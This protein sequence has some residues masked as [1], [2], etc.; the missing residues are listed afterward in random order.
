MRNGMRVID[1][2]A[3]SYHPEGCRR[4]RHAG[5]ISRARDWPDYPFLAHEN[6]DLY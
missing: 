2:T 6:E 5:A 1:Q 4:V 3:A